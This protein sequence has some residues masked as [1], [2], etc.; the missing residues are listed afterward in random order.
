[1]P[2]QSA[3]P[4]KPRVNMTRA[5]AEARALIWKHRRSLSVGLALMLVNRLAGLVLPA[6]SKY[7]IDDVLGKQRVDLL[8]PL[9]LAVGGATLIQAITSFA[10]SQTV[11][12]AAQRAISDMRVEIQQHVLRLPVSFF[13]STKS[14]VLITRVM[15]DAEGIR[16][17]IGTG[18]VQLTGGIITAVIALGVLFYLN[19]RLTASTIFVLLAFGGMMAVAFKRLRPLFRKRNEI[20]AEVTGRL[21][22]ALGGI[23]TVK[24]YTAEARE[25]R[26]FAEGIERL[27]RNIASTI[28]GTS[29]VGAATTVIVGVI[30]VLMIIIGGRSIVGGTMTLGDFVM[31]I[32]FIG[33]VAAPLVQIASIGTQVSEAFAGLDRI[34]EIRN[35]STEDQEDERRAAIGELEGHVAFENVSFE[36][37]PGVPVLRDISFTTRAGTTTA[38]VG[39]SGAGKSTLIGLVSAFNRPTSGRVLVDGRDAATLRLR[40]YRANLGVVMQDNFLFD[41]TVRDNIAFAKPDATDEEIRA[42]SRIAHCDEFIERFEAKYDTI[43]GERGVKLSGGQ[44]QRVA[45]ARAILADPRILILD[46][47]TS[48]LDSES[49]AL[50]RD[51][52]RSLRRGRTTFV[53]AH[54]LSTIESADQILVMEEGRI[55]ERGTHAELL[56]ANGRYRQLYDKQYRIERDQFINPGEDFLPVPVPEGSVVPVPRSTR[57]AL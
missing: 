55:V 40:D 22:E 4:K 18:L 1:M 37:V 33:L 8:V 10:L 7:L 20:N 28:T 44:R 31:Y 48:S 54:R 14:G 56:A 50:I 17:L 6:S 9:A 41:G 35:T 19:W 25:E 47:A 29:A 26:I 38:L 49:E 23:R 16:N 45:I 21:G 24:V 39:S 27:F 52:L 12:I 13:D 42:V 15:S 30:G 51:G 34:R 46:E 53:I 11:S 2:D 32:F 36:Y 3:P 43:V 57:G 5:W